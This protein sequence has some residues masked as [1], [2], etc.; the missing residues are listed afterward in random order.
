MYYETLLY[1]FT[2]MKIC[3]KNSSH[4]IKLNITFKKWLKVC[5]KNDRSKT[6]LYIDLCYSF[7]LRTK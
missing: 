2:V 1:A 7:S 6:E 3:V 4:I 5:N